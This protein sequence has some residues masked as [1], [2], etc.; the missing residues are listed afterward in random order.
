MEDT[1]RVPWQSSSQAPVVRNRPVFTQEIDDAHSESDVETELAL[2][3]ILDA[4]GRGPRYCRRIAT[5]LAGLGAPPSLQIN[6]LATLNPK[7]VGLTLARH[8]G[9]PGYS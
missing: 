3:M 6:V 8:Y 9:V 4:S 5:G 1:D 2:A 7:E